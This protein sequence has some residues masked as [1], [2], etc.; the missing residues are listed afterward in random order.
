MSLLCAALLHGASTYAVPTH[1]KRLESRQCVVTELFTP[2]VHT[3]VQK[4][5]KAKTGVYV[6]THAVQINVMTTNTAPTYTNHWYEAPV[7]AKLLTNKP[8][9]QKVILGP[10]PTFYTL[11]THNVWCRPVLVLLRMLTQTFHNV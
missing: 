4:A 6:C 7:F 2:M 9:S 3:C 1:K 8:V 10:V 11:L 5:Q